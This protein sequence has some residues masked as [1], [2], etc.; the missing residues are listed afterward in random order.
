MKSK[1]IG[2]IARVLQDVKR[3]SVMN[4]QS[5]NDKQIGN[6]TAPHGCLIHALISIRYTD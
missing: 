1:L 6:L 3:A 2:S 4:A 5:L